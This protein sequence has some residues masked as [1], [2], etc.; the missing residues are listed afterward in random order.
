MFNERKLEIL[1]LLN[2]GNRWTSS[3]VADELGL[4]L[5]NASELLRR[6]YKQALVVRTRRREVGAPPRAYIYAISCKGT[7]RLEYLLDYE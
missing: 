2:D 4:S 1:I 3:E 7:E 6:Y 5:S